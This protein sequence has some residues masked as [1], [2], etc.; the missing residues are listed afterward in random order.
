MFET[1]DRDFKRKPPL[2]PEDKARIAK[3]HEL[4]RIN[5]EA[6][7]TTDFQKGSDIVIEQGEDMRVVRAEKKEK[8]EKVHALDVL[9]QEIQNEIMVQAREELMKEAYSPQ[10]IEEMAMDR[11]RKIAKEEFGSKG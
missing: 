10:K 3:E 4:A 9:S 8:G 6:Q 1:M 11:A 7:I 5:E 2:T